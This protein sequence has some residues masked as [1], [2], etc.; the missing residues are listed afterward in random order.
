MKKTYSVMKANTIEIMK[1]NFPFCTL[2]IKFLKCL[3][4][5]YDSVLLTPNRWDLFHPPIFKMIT[6]KL[7]KIVSLESI[8]KKTAGVATISVKIQYKKIKCIDKLNK[9]K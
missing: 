5:T 4:I 9:Y 2:K 3:S 7:N 1:Y 6:L 8:R